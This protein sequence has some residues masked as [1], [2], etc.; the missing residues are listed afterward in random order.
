MKRHILFASIFA[1][2]IAFGACSSNNEPPTPT[3]QDEIEAAWPDLYEVAEVGTFVKVMRDTTGM[4]IMGDDNS[5]EANEAPAHVVKFS[6]SYYIGMLEV[7]QAQWTAIMGSNPSDIKGDNLPVNNIKYS[8]ATK[9]IEKLNEKTGLAFRLPTEAEWEYAAM[10]G[11]LSQGYTYSGSNNV[12]EVAWYAGNSNDNLQPGGLKKANELGI[13]DMTGNVAEWCKDRCATY[14][15]SEQTDPEGKT[16][17]YAVRGGRFDDTTNGTNYLRCKARL[18]MEKSNK[19]Y[20]LGLR[21]LLEEP[22]TAQ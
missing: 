11:K 15:A 18:G 20:N 2:A 16:G 3:T 12:D 7:T 21:L 22:K 10:G 13:Y 1:M 6:K 5:T 19:F 17:G 4:F 8:D 14:K 9:F